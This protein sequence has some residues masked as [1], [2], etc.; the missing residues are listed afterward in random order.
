MEAAA[1]Q[2]RGLLTRTILAG[3]VHKN[4]NYSHFCLFLQGKKDKKDFFFRE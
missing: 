3:D 1:N 4:R 2:L